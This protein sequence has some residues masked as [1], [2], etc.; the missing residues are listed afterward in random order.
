M[1]EGG[2]PRVEGGGLDCLHGNE[3]DVVEGVSLYASR[4]S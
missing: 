1:K 3:S 2:G 4:K